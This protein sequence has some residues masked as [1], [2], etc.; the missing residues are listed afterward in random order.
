MKRVVVSASLLLLISTGAFAQQSLTQKLAG[1]W[2]LKEGREELANGQKRTPW[3]TGQL[4]FDAGG[5][6]SFLIVGKDR[7][8]PSSEDPRVPVGPL[9]AYYGTFTEADG[10]VLLNIEHGSTTPLEGAKRQWAIS[11]DG[12]LMRTAGKPVPTHEGPMTPVN[13]WTRAK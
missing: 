6:F 10:A 12:E 11:F 4:M 7:A 1:T 8:K 13:D 3:L 5:H 9:V 2:T